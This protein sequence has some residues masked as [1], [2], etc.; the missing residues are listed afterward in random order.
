MVTVEYL[1]LKIFGFISVHNHVWVAR[2]LSGGLHANLHDRY[3]EALVL[4]GARADGA[5]MRGSDLIHDV[6]VLPGT[7]HHANMP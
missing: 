1:R 3:H 2:F 7:F 5:V 4:G 6:R